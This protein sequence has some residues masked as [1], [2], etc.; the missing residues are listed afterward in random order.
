MDITEAG[1]DIITTLSLLNTHTNTNKQALR[2]KK[3]SEER[4]LNN[5]WGLEQWRTN[6]DEMESK[7]L[8]RQPI[9]KSGLKN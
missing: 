5:G 4:E 9:D 8:N 6:L 1:F 2:K 3:I 7:I